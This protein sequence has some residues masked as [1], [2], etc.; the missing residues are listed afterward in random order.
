MSAPENDANL[1]GDMRAL[2][3][4]LR[5]IR[6]EGRRC[7]DALERAYP[8]CEFEGKCHSGIDCR[9]CRNF[10][11]ACE[12][13]AE[14]DRHRPLVGPVLERAIL[15]VF[16]R[17]PFTGM[18]VPSIA[19]WIREGAASRGRY[20]TGLTYAVVS[21]ALA[22]MANGGPVVRYDDGTWGAK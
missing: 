8:R 7:A 6:D 9:L 22:A 5:E 13:G 18:N 16:E 2:V 14:C 12:H 3:V 11:A 21:D 17:I 15:D 1:C 10:D 20:P 4:V 19:S